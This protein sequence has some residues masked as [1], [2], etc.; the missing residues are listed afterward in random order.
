MYETIT[1]TC[2]KPNL[3]GDLPIMDSKRKQKSGNLDNITTSATFER[4]VPN[5]LTR[6]TN[7]FSV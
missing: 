5:V 6:N 3:E 2:T 4:I 7:I 1:I